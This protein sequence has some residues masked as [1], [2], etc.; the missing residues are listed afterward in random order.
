MV[1][2]EPYNLAGLKI[3]M[4]QYCSNGITHICDKALNGQDALDCV[5]KAYNEG[6]WS[7]GLIF[8]DCSMPIM[9]GFEATD[10]IRRYCSSKIIMQPMIVANTGHTEDMY[11][12]KCWRYEMDEVVSKP[13]DIHIIHQI[14]S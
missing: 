9:D 5:K 11:I 4:R 13:T 6:N 8:M 3:M 7:Y 12:Q 14:L 1:D 10:R 2:D